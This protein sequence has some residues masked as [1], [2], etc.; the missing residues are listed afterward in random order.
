MSFRSFRTASA[1]R[2]LQILFYAGFVF[3]WFKDNFPL[4][5]AIRFS[6]L[7]PLAGLILATVFRAFVK[8][9]KSRPTRPPLDKKDGIAIA[10]ILLL[11]TAVHVPLLVHN[12]GLMDSDEAIPALQGK[13]IAEG[14]VPAL[15][16]YGARFQGSLPQHYY[17]FLFR[18][19]G[20]SVFLVKLAAFLAF[21]AFLLVQ[22]FLIKK[23]FSRE[24]AILAGVFSVLPFPNLLISSFDVGSGF[25][26]LFLLGS[27][28]FAL[29]YEIYERGKDHLLGPLG[30]VLGLAFWTHQVSIVFIL[31]SAFFLVLRFKLQIRKYL[32]LALFLGLGLLPVIISEFYWGFLLVRWLLFGGEASGR[33]PGGKVANGSRLLLELFSSGPAWANILY[34]AVLGLGLFLLA[35]RMTGKR[36]IPMSFLFVVYFLVYAAVYLFSSFSSTGII[37]YLYILYLALPVL[38]VSAFSW[39]STRPLRVAATALFF[40]LVFFGSSAKSSLDYYQTTGTRHREL[41][42]VAAA[43]VATGEKYWQGH[44]W[45]SYLLNAVAK[46]RIIVASSTVVRYPAY[47]LEHD[48]EGV[49]TNRV[50]L[51][52]T[53]EQDS[54]AA[55]F[56]HMLSQLKKTYKSETLGPWYLV[57][58]ITGYVYPKNVFFPPEEIPDVSLDDIVAKESGL[59]LRFESKKPLATGGF[60]LSAEIEG[61]CRLFTP[62]GPGDRFSLDLPYPPE[63]RATLKFYIDFQGLYLDSTL[64]ESIVDLPPP[65]PAA[66][67]AAIEPLWGFGP[68][69][70]NTGKN[71]IALE[72][73]VRFRV[74]RAPG[75]GGN[76]RLGLYAPFQFADTFWHD[77][78]RQ[79]A[80][81]FVNDQSVGTYDLQDGSNTLDVRIRFPPFKNGPNI[82]RL[83][84][85]YAMVISLKQDHW[86]TAAYLEEMK[87][88]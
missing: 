39:I 32:V 18:I 54:S 35:K 51:R 59:E 41:K 8:S 29:T 67:R 26:V 48:T 13:H 23:I 69:E 68:R 5:R 33:L 76:I 10:L 4:F 60:R 38:F 58:G 20:Y 36:K 19:F 49:H 62:I 88:D 27:V 84:F 66:R 16:Y 65:P 9:K 79:N 56:T 12:Y 6:P 71:W 72:R 21:A 52:D 25:A 42:A 46:E 86:K 55:E 82:V 31:T 85:K 50:F 87:I 80:E 45:I 22:Y 81:V 17:A 74:D 1:L 34:L 53:A 44:Y 14:H 63:R 47:L 3:L 30:F 28:I 11:A 37:R 7:V 64:R 75:E 77:P 83:K 24:T 15:F 57:Y 78:F 2:I 73:D 40:A 43:M 70:K 61:F